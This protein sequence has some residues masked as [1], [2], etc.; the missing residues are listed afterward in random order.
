MRSSRQMSQLEEL[1]MP[2]HQSP[3]KG[4]MVSITHDASASAEW[5]GLT[6]RGTQASR[7]HGAGS[8]Q[9]CFERRQGSALASCTGTLQE[10]VSSL[11]NA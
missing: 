10:R 3:Y 2:V 5:A 7:P 4:W 11:Y 8:M 6:K 1:A 9:R